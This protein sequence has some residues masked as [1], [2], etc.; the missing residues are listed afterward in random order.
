M[1]ACRLVGTALSLH[2]S[3]WKESLVKPG[4][5]AHRGPLGLVS[6][7][8]NLPCERQGLSLRAGLASPRK[9]GQQAVPSPAVSQAPGAGV[10]SPPGTSPACS[11]SPQ[12]HYH[13][14]R[15]AGVF[16]LLHT[17]GKSFLEFFILNSFFLKC[18][19]HI[20][21]IG[22]NKI[23]ISLACKVNYSCIYWNKIFFFF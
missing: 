19:W 9:P 11:L 4:T 5:A 3:S 15:C 10:R 17:R 1:W 7:T 23:D 20:F 18:M 13:R 21:L 22:L 8:W 14:Q 12:C 16:V 2:L 6:D